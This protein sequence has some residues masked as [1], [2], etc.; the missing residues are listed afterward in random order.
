MRIN[1][2]DFILYS[3][4]RVLKYLDRRKCGIN[5]FNPEKILSIL[6]VSSTAIGDTILSTAAIKAVRK[7]YPSA[8]I[9]AHFNIKNM[10]LFENNSDIDGIIPYYGGYKKFFYTIKAL[11]KERFDLALIFHGNE[12][13]STPMAYLSGANFII[14]L[15]N[16]NEYRFLLSNNK[17]IIRWT[18]FNH[19]IEQR[20]RV[21]ELAGCNTSDKR[22]HLPLSEEGD[23]FANKFLKENGIQN[24]DIL[25][26]LQTGASTVS[27]MWFAERFIELGKRLIVSYPKLKIVITGSP[28][29]YDHCRKIADTIGEKAV[30]SARQVPLKYLPSLIHR[31]KLLVS[32]DT[33]TMHM[34]AAVGTPLVALFAVS[35]PE[36][37][38]PY[39]DLDR[40]IV[41]NKDP[42]CNPCV[43]KKCEYQKCMEQISVDEVFHAVKTIISRGK[44]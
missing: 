7:Q 12:P 16:T 24:T 1:P 2:K 40:N 11:R 44:A 28:A 9:I 8:K 21:A 41:I 13:Q 26:G 6:A 34:A 17:Q 32:G 23:L 5:D 4:L 38:G 29:E 10:E 36:K 3:L 35:D 15:P 14:K 30:V 22:M 43:S 19:A 18:D 42:I 25:I 33:G 37:S 27:R 31:L 39:Y 20:I